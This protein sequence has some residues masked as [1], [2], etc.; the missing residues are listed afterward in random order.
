MLFHWKFVEYIGTKLRSFF[1]PLLS[2][3]GSQWGRY[4]GYMDVDH[5]LSMQLNEFAKLQI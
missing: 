5:P 4:D 3:K 2:V 1:Q